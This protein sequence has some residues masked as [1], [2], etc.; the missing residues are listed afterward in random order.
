MS[1]E[2]DIY[3]V[4]RD[5]LSSAAGTLLTAQAGVANGPAWDVLQE[6]KSDGQQLLVCAFQTDQGVQTINV[7]PTGL[8]A[9]TTYEVRSVDTGLLGT[10]TGSELMARGVDLV[11]SSNSA[12]HILLLKAK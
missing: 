12:A 8:A 1:H 11:Q 9:A 6:S 5:T 10:A 4:M 3:K 7:K 2:I